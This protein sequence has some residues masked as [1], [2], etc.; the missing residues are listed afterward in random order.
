[1]VAGWMDDA[2]AEALG[3]NESEKSRLFFVS[4]WPQPFR[5]NYNRSKSVIGKVRAAIARIDHFIKT[6]GVE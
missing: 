6:K 3:L 1:M 4:G 5:Q 2:G